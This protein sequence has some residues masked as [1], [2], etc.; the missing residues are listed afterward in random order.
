MHTFYSIK[1]SD[2]MKKRVESNFVYPDEINISFRPT[3]LNL[4]IWGNF[5]IPIL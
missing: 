1:V 5:F 3:R 2:F 4:F